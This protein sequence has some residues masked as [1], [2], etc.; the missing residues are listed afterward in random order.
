MVAAAVELEANA[1]VADELVDLRSVLAN[2]AAVV[3][4]VVAVGSYFGF[5]LVAPNGL[6]AVAVVVIFVANVVVVE[7]EAMVVFQPPAVAISVL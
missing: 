5:Q 2:V 6:V 7:G 4:Q 1:I 3:V